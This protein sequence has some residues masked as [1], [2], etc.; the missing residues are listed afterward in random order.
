MALRSVQRTSPLGPERR[1]VG[2]SEIVDGTGRARKIHCALRR[3]DPEADFC[4]RDLCRAA[5]AVNTNENEN[6]SQ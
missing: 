2:K 3:A 5:G 1:Q 6:H 4:Y